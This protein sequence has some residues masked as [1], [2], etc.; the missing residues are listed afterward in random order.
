MAAPDVEQVNFLVRNIAQIVTGATI[1]LLALLSYLGKRDSA[2]N[3][4]AMLIEVPVSHAELLACQMEVNKVIRTEFDL[5][6]KDF[7]SEI[8]ELHEKVNTHIKE[9]KEG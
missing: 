4:R 2:K 6:R 1:L 7:M 8:K 5:L 9:C 3:A